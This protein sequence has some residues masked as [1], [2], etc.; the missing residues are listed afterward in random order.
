MKSTM[1]ALLVV[2]IIFL[3]LP[4]VVNSDNIFIQN[5]LESSRV[6]SA[7]LETDTLLKELFES[8]GCMYPPKKIFIRVFKNEKLLE[9]WAQNT[10][11]SKFKLIKKYPFCRSSGDLGPKRR[12]GDGQIP[13]GFYYI[14]RFNS[15]S[16]F[17][18][19]LG[20]NYPNDSDRILGDRTYIGGDIFIHGDCVT[21]GCIPITDS[22]IKE[23]YWIAIQAKANGQHII[24]VHIFPTPLNEEGIENL[25]A[26]YLNNENLIF[27]WKNLEN[28]YDFFET[29]KKIPMIRV[30][31]DGTYRI[32]TS[33]SE[34]FNIYLQTPYIWGEDVIWVQEKLKEL[35][36]SITVDGIYGQE[37]ANQV[38][39]FQE[40]NGL[41]VDGIIG[42]N[43]LYSLSL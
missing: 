32:P 35:G 27:F 5:Q 10:I 23:L 4:S 40:R 14:N 31:T 15:W 8:K 21:I 43:T 7:K 6:R 1:K 29:Y 25:K 28:G 12:E 36:Y 42:P 26:E 37:T 17:Y 16:R 18:L 13:E 3:I 19:S 2:V 11:E 22:M 39:L 30:N 38:R 41:T 9:L 33:P 20:I 34:K 24:P